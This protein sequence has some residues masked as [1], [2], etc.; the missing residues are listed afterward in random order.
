[1]GWLIE[2]K[3]KVVSKKE[4]SLFLIDSFLSTYTNFYF[5]TT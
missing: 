2:V 4:V 5:L 3:Q 1:M